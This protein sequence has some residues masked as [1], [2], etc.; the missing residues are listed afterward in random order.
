MS[1]TI[2]VAEDQEHIRSLITYK[3]R[4]S[5]YTVVTAVDGL[6]AIKKAE[7][8]NPDL[9]LLDVMMPLL[10]GFEVL[11]RLK[12]HEKL[13]TIPVLMVTAQ[14]QEDEVIKGLELGADDY[15][16]KPFSPNELVARVKTVLLRR[17]KQ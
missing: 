13:K 12:Q 14:S 1:Q 17:S 7:E 8:T 6:E 4:H 2:L 5:G 16:T 3:L 11:A 10:T 9:I 15:I